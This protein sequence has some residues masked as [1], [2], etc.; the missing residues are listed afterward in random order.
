[1]ANIKISFTA[2]EKYYLVYLK[3]SI[4]SDFGGI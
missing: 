3:H 1:M 4:L 2:E